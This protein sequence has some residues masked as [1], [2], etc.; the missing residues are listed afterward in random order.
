MQ[1]VGSNELIAYTPEL[2]GTSLVSY[3]TAVSD[4]QRHRRLT[5]AKSFDKDATAEVA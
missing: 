3:E 1:G 2:Y 5:R 4:D